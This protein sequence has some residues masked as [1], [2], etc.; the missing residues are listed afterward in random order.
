MSTR[1][2]A[3]TA[4]HAR[5]AGGVH[6]G[7]SRLVSDREVLAREHWGRT[8]LLTP[9]ALLPS[10]TDLFSA[11]AV[12]ELLSERGLRTPFV[13]MA[14]DGRTLPDR[15]FTASGGVGAT[16]GDQVSEDKVLAQFARGASIVLQ[17]LHRTWA[18]VV[19][20]AQGVAADLGHHVQV[21]AYITPPDNRGFDVHYDVH[22][23]FVLQ[24]EGSK[25]WQLREPVLP[26][27]LRTQPSADRQVQVAAA[28]ESEPWL[29]TVLAPGDCLYLPRG[30]LHSATAL[31]RTSIHLTVGVHVWTVHHVLEQ[32]AAQAVRALADQADA[33]ASLP[34]GVDIGDPDALAAV[35]S[36]W[37]PRLAEAVEA[38]LPSA[39]SAGLSAVS[40]AAQRAGPLGVLRQ[41]EAAGQAGTRWVPRAHL[42]SSWVDGSLVTRVGTV[43]VD[44][45][46]RSVV[47]TVLAGGDADDLRPE[48]ARRLALAGILVPDDEGSPAVDGRPVG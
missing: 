23:V 13:K 8:P 7:L 35:L 46:D 20:L 45:S 11:A 6:C 28:G 17:G 10:P 30:W 36:Q 34:M 19:T 42:H 2:D 32:V 22:D 48:L 47:A 43:P 18:P 39:L 14:K 26:N 5:P 25:R 40:G 4:V 15:A 9:G 29:D 1:T 3:L 33:R 12:D 31:G 37:A 44:P 38:V 16:I 24:V 21:N 41:M 27:P